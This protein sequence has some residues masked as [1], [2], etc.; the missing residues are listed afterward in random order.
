MSRALVFGGSGTVG[1]EVVRGLA[2]RG[3]R[4]LFTYLR[5][6]DRAAALARETGFVARQV[7]LSDARALAAFLGELAAPDVFVSCAA[8]ARGGAM[9]ETSDGDWDAAVAVNGRAPFVACRA[10]A[11][12]MAAA[13]GGSIVLVGA[14]D[15]TQSLPLPVA[16]AATQGMLPAL[17][18]ALA[19]ELGPAGI[20]VNAVALGPLD[21][22]LSR[23]LHPTRVEEY[24]QYSA[25]QR[26][27]KPAEVVA[28]ILWLALDARYMNGKVLAVNGGI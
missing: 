27:G 28:A 16:F 10:L 3:V 7:D 25:L 26:L 9:A 11:P 6:E 18:M 21:A 17:A 4:G 5:A 22:G 13:G 12:A 8:V 20:R 24:R 15:R 23:V 14:L 19:H 1:A 2:A